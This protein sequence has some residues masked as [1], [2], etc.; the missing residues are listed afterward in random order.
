MKEIKYPDIQTYWIA[1]NIDVTIIQYGNTLSEQITT[2]GLDNLYS[3][4]D[5]QEFI[6]VLKNN[7][8]IDYVD[9]DDV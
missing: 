9:I 2:T 4:I 6:S 5:K 7:Y 1:C 8:N 3:Y